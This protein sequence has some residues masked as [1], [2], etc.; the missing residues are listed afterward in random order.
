MSKYNNGNQ[1]DNIVFNELI[2]TS[3]KYFNIYNKKYCKI[4]MLFGNKRI[5]SIG[6]IL[7]NIYIWFKYKIW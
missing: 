5:L 2:N 4:N 3:N 6:S 7:N 1:F